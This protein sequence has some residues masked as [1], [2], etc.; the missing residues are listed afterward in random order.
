MGDRLLG[1]VTGTP[2]LPPDEAVK[3]TILSMRRRTRA[4]LNC[5]GTFGVPL[6]S[7]DGDVGEL[8]SCFKGVKDTRG[9]RWE[10][11]ISLKTPRLS[12]GAAA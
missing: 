10:G 12:V 4:L 3:R 8:L 5:E 2:G 9:F 7:A 6:E 11:G 1:G